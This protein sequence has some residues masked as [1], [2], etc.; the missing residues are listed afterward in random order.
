MNYFQQKNLGFDTDQIIAIE[1]YGELG[2][3]MRNNPGSFKSEIMNHHSINS[4][5]MSSNLPGE[6]FS[7]ED[8]RQESIPEDVE[9]PP[10]RY[11]RVDKDFIETL[12]IEIVEGKSFADWTSENPAFILNEKA[13]KSIQLDEPIGKIASNF[14]GTEAEIVGIAKDFNFASLHNTIEPLVLELNPMWCSKILVEISA[15][16]I[17]QSID[18]LRNKVEELY[19]DTTVRL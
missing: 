9:I 2:N 15:N 14:R 5:A 10:I 17:P 6:R 1:L 3:M 4:V 13:L 7:V 18:F 19:L 11:L 8:I 16:D 12:G